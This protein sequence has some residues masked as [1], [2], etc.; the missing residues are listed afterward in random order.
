MLVSLLRV[1]ALGMMYAKWMLKNKLFYLYLT[2]FMPFTILVPFYLLVSAPYRSYV[3]I[4]TIVLTIFSNSL[5]TASQDIAVDKIMK[6]IAVI[7]TKPIT[8]TEYFLGL[9]ISNAMQ[10]F[11]AVIISILV[12]ISIGIL[13]IYDVAFLTVGL[14]AAWYVSTAIGFIIGILLSN[15]DYHTVVLVGNIV[16]F[17]LVFLAPIYYPPSNLPEPLRT[18]TLILPSLHV[19]NLI[20]RSC[21]VEYGIEVNTS[22]IYVLALALILTIVIAKKIRLKDIY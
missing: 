1:Y 8:S 19:A 9:T 2:L 14:L 6:R 17:I 18:L 15:R 13:K 22:T 3:A 12:L 20:G 16:S 4:G 21:N 7:I 10:A 5:V 11:P